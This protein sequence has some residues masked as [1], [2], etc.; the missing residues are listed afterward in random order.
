MIEWWG[1][2]IFEYYGAT[3]FGM[4]TRCDSH[5]WLARPGTTGKAW[6]DR[7]VEIHGEDG[8]L[9]P[10]HE[11]GEVYVSLGPLADFT[12]HNKEDQR[13][14]I[15]RRGLVTAG[16]AGY[17]DE[18]GYLFLTDRKRDMVIS[19]GVNIYPAEIESEIAAH[20][21]VAD[22]AVFGVPDSEFGETVVAAHRT[23]SR[24]GRNARRTGDF[25]PGPPRELQGSEAVL[26]PQETSPRRRRQKSGSES[27]GSLSGRGWTAASER[28]PHPPANQQPPE[29]G[30][31]HNGEALPGG[32]T[33]RR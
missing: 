13:R 23:G 22:S 27:F 25:P 33:G 9:L 11:V 10:P 12:Y 20:P 16:D 28:R 32:A 26:P 21:S 17:L 14:E 7:V 29:S 31:T 15:E 6:S 1:P 18:D 3:E 5:E 19:G 2:I 24:P 4:V 30:S 8:Q